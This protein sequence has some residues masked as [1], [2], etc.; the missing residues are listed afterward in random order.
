MA[1]FARRRRTLEARGASRRST[2]TGAPRSMTTATVRPAVERTNSCI[3][4]AGAGCPFTLV[5]LRCGLPICDDGGRRY[6]PKQEPI[7]CGILL[8]DKGASGEG[9]CDTPRALEDGNRML[10]DR[11]LITVTLARQIMAETLLG[12]RSGGPRWP[13]VRNSSGGHSRQTSSL[14]CRTCSSQTACA[15]SASGSARIYRREAR[16]WGGARA[17][18]QARPRLS[19]R[20]AA[21]ARRHADSFAKAVLLGVAAVLCAAHPCAAFTPST[22]VGRL[23]ATRGFRATVPS[24]FGTVFR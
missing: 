1:P 4:K 8:F 7:L 2:L 24:A 11:M 21:T 14:I 16:S 12:P 3:L 17:A 20:A 18:V 15:S 23:H 22:S 10:E 19:P 6:P 5:P 13:V 9:L